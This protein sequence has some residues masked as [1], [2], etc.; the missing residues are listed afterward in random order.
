MAPDLRERLKGIK[1]LVLDVDGV[2]TNASLYYGPQGEAHKRFHVRD[3]LGIRML[4]HF[5]IEV[6]VISARK[7]SLVQQR[8][9]DLKIARWHTGKE[10]KLEALAEIFQ[11]NSL[12]L[13]QTAYV[14]M[15]SSTSPYA[16][17]GRR[18]CSGRCPS[19]YKGRCPPHDPGSR[20]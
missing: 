5:G 8:M 11:A 15:T 12:S 4:Q 19:V 16:Q 7:S 6:A 1:L 17:G 3:G 13:A 14:E 20:W 10:D 2:L 9:T 18:V